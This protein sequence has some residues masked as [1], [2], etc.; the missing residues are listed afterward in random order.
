MNGCCEQLVVDL[1]KDTSLTYEAKAL[2][3]GDEQVAAYFI[4]KNDW[5]VCSFIIYSNVVIAQLIFSDHL[6][7]YNLSDPNSIA[8][9]K[10]AFTELEEPSDNYQ[11]LTNGHI[12]TISIVVYTIVYAILH[13]FL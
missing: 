5:H 12:R 6:D 11:C 10:T 8:E 13:S 7:D 4:F 1:V 9:L 3:K 2:S